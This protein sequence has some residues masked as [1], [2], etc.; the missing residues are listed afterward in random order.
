M[1]IRTPATISGFRP[2]M[3]RDRRPVERQGVVR[4]GDAERFGQ[5]AR[6]RA[7]R[8]LIVQTAAPAHRRQAVGRLQRAD[9]H[10]AGRAFLLADEIHAPVDAVGAIDI[11]KAG[12]AEHHLVPRRRAAEGVRRRVG[13][14]IGLDLDND[15]ADAVDQ[16][17]RADQVGRDLVHAAGEKRALQRLAEPGGDGAC[18]FGVLNHLRWESGGTGRICANILHVLRDGASRVAVPGNTD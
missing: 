8:A 7:Q 10:G 4:D 2:R 14:M 12:R 16:Q 6:A 5:L 17:R 9:Q 3:Q 11:G 1:P 15:A 18:R 13:V